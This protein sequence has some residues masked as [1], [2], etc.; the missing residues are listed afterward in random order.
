MSSDSLNKIPDKSEYIKAWN[1]EAKHHIHV[2]MLTDDSPLDTE[3]LEIL[4]HFGME[5]SNIVKYNNPDDIPEKYG[6]VRRT[7][8]QSIKSLLLKAKREEDYHIRNILQ[9]YHHINTNIA[10]ATLTDRISD[11]NKLIEGETKE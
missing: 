11:L 7:T 2:P 3:I 5:V 4:S 1:E 10:E 6:V 8:K 9:A